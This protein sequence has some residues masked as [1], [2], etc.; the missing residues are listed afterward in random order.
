MPEEE[1]LSSLERVRRRLYSTQAPTD[2]LLTGYTKKPSE[3]T[4]GW[5][6]LKVAQAAIQTETQHMSGPARFFISALGFFLVT[7]IAT[8]AYLYFGGRS[9]STSTLRES[10]AYIRASRV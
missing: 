9:I 1:H 10:V 4:R 2:T 7:L 8:G 5:D 6:T 3:Q